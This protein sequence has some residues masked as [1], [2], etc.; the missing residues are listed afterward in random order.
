M[1]DSGNPYQ[2][3][4][5]TG[6]VSDQLAAMRDN[7]TKSVILQPEQVVTK[8]F[9]Q[10]KLRGAE[11]SRRRTEQQVAHGTGAS[12]RTEMTTVTSEDLSEYER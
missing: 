2:H 8:V 10:A 7:R 1:L 6:Q 3:N 9:E 11:S 4:K 5:A 12:Q